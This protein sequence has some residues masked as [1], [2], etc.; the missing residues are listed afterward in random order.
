MRSWHARLG[1]GMPVAAR[2]TPYV[3]PVRGSDGFDNGVAGLS[4]SF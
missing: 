3:A 4:V 1:L 2:M